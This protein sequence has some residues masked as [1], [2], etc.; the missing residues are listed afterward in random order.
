MIGSALI[1]HSFSGAQ[2]RREFLPEGLVCSI[3][4]PIDSANWQASGPA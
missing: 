4:L 1:D 3:E 2:I